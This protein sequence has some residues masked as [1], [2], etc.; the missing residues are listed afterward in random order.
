M[1]GKKKQGLCASKNQLPAAKSGREGGSLRKNFQKH[2][3]KGTKDY[4]PISKLA[5]LN[6]KLY[7]SAQQ[8]ANQAL[9][10]SINSVLC[11]YSCSFSLQ[12]REATLLANADERLQHYFVLSKHRSEANAGRR[13]IET[14]LVQS[15]QSRTQAEFASRPIV[16]FSANVYTIML[17]HALKRR[18]LLRK[19]ASLQTHSSISQPKLWNKEL[20][21][22][23]SVRDRGES[24]LNSS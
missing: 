10:W 17:R 16:H 7:A 6:H 14:S 12:L 22:L 3:R 4:E 18:E 20:P 1:L 15:I 13:L 11:G 23:V 21:T 5:L 2:S 19:A 9:L 8:F 24:Q